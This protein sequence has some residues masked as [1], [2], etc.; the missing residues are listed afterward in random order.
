MHDTG[1]YPALQGDSATPVRLWSHESLRRAQILIPLTSGRIVDPE[2]IGSVFLP[3][4]SP[5]HG[6][7]HVQLIGPQHREIGVWMYG[8]AA[9]FADYDRRHPGHAEQIE[10]AHRSF[11]VLDAARRGWRHNAASDSQHRRRRKSLVRRRVAAQER[12]AAL[13]AGGLERSEGRRLGQTD[14][15]VW[16]HFTVRGFKHPRLRVCEQCAMVFAGRRHA[17][18]C[19]VCRRHRVRLSLRPVESGGWHLAFRVGDRRGEFSTT[20]HY[21]A[22]CRSCETPFDTTHPQR[23]LCRNCGEGSGRVRR[24][25]RSSSRTG[26]QRFRYIHPDGAQ[27]F[28]VSTNTLSGSMIALSSVDGVI[29]TDDAEVAWYLDSLGT[30]RRAS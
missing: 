3:H 13:L 5:E 2:R 19:D 18:L 14:E 6:W 4:Y 21:T 17:R 16:L 8:I 30:L 20:V 11:V 9:T 28:S 25:R 26:R 24:H 10:L 1:D 27:E 12:L 29:E 23:R 22:V 15:R 7:G